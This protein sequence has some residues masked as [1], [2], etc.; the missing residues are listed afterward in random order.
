M[1]DGSL[2]TKLGDTEFATLDSLAYAF[3]PPQLSATIKQEFEDFRVDEEL[4]FDCTGQGEH[5]Y[6]R[7][8]KQ[9]LSTPDVAKRLQALTRL[10]PTAIGYS[11]MKDRRGDCTQWFSVQLPM[12]EEGRINALE[13]AGLTV[14][15]TQRN[16]RKLK[17]GSHKQNHFQI[18]LRNCKGDLP[19]FADRLRQIQAAGIPNYFGEQ[20]FGR[21]LSNLSQVQSLMEDLLGNRNA[22]ATRRGGD[23]HFKRG[24]LYSAARAYLFNQVLSQRVASGSWDSYVSGDVPNL[25]GT[26]RCFR[27][28]EGAWDETLQRRLR[29]FDI[30]LTGPLA[31][32]VD[33]KDKYISRDKAADIEEAVLGEYPALVKGLVSCGLVA[34]RRPLRFMP[35]QLQWEWESSASL[36]LR[37]SLSRGCYATSLLR[38]ICSVASKEQPQRDQLPVDQ[39]PVDQ[40]PADQQPSD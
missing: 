19:S 28:A 4:G 22:S 29:E 12:E 8:R 31:G 23:Q 21:E 15:E 32:M 34:S 6:L 2:E 20:R 18:R 3:G 30:H 10:P 13:G 35:G 1:S 24:M 7:V 26:D 27:V 9:D 37:F 17:I 40:L 38:E 39:L 36:C 5:L 16:G 14:L 33:P 11:G 25:A